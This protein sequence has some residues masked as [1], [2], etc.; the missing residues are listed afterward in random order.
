MQDYL[1]FGFFVQVWP[2][3]PVGFLLGCFFTVWNRTGTE[4]ENQTF[5]KFDNLSKTIA[6]SKNKETSS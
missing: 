4:R 1:V 6:K 5:G 3:D 2:P